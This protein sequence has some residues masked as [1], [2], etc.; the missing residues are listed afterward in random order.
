MAD[1]EDNHFMARALALARQG[2]GL[3][4]PNPMVG[5]VLVKDGQVIAEGLH[6]YAE[7]KHAEIWA[8]EAAG[9]NAKGA[10]L[11]INL[12]PCSHFGRTPPCVERVI[13]AGIRR[14]MIAMV[15]PNPRV[16]GEGIHRLKDAGIEVNLGIGKQEAERL[17]ESYAK[18]I[19]SR[20]PL[21]ILKTAMT[22]DGKIAQADGHSKWITGERARAKGQQLRFDCDALLTGIGT[23]LKDDPL[24]TDRTGLNRR[25]PLLRCVLDS[26]L[27]FPLTS[28]LVQS[29]SAGA[30]MVFCSLER[31]LA[32]QHELESAGI[33]VVAVPGEPGQLSWNSI[34]EELGRREITSL[35]IEAGPTLNYSAFRHGAVDKMCCFIAPSILGGTTPLPLL[36]EPG[37]VNL[38][39]VIR[40]RFASVELLGPDLYVEAY[41]STSF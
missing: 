14:T 22:L 34:L 7:R 4:S 8:I 39:D 12:E 28:R 23:V 3:V 32:R 24:L 37:F 13:E 18:Y 33:E 30:I 36:G 5:A 35:L 15:D 29:R 38:G 19:Q 21:V 26:R 25:R 9:D 17:N 20:T 10:T 1:Q 11:Y 6:R 31:D 27:Q 2:R 40:L 16:A 41:P